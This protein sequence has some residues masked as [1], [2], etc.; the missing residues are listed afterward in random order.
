[1][2]EYIYLIC[3]I[4][5]SELSIYTRLYEEMRSLGSGAFGEVFA[6]KDKYNGQEYAVKKIRYESNLMIFRYILIMCC[7]LVSLLVFEKASRTADFITIFQYGFLLL[8]YYLIFFLL[9]KDLLSFINLKILI[10]FGNI[11][12]TLYLIHQYIGRDLLL[13]NLYN[14]HKQNWGVSCLISI[15]MS[16]FLS[17]IITYYCE[18][19]LRNPLKKLLIIGESYGNHVKN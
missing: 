2:I 7:F 15:L 8:I 1:M 4:V 16:I 3:F 14:Y 5:V 18:P 6:V 10:F 17:Y 19:L 13:K 11:S 9:I 12:Y